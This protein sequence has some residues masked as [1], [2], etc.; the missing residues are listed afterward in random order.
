MH[1]APPVAFP[2]GR[3]VWGARIALLLALCTLGLG[4]LWLGQPG[5][6]VRPG[7]CWLLAWLA[8]ALASIGWARREALPAGQLSWDGQAWWFE[9]HGGQP[10]RAARVQVVWDGQSALLLQLCLQAGSA[11]R[12]ARGFALLRAAELP[13]PWHGLR[14][15]VHAHDTL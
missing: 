8:L 6:P 2:V 7:L 12:A 14:C 10:P 11:Q 15:A 3:F 5:A 13:G 1:S 9:A 4:L